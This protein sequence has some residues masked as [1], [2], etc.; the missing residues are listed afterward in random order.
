ML[1]LHIKETTFFDDRDQRFIDIGETTI[2][3]E[4]SLV[5]ISKWEAKWKKSFISSKEKSVEELLDYIRMMTI[6]QNVKPE[7]YL[8]ITEEQFNEVCQYIEDPMTA[9]TF[10]D[11]KKST[12][13]SIITS[14]LVY[15][16][17]IECGIPME[18]QKW[19][20]N[21][22]MTLIRVCKIKMK[23]TSKMTKS[24]TAKMYNNLNEQRKAKLHTR[25]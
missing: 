18:C 8:A 5:S 12:S 23:P 14:E 15:Y 10:N 1:R 20:F 22:L 17:M 9:T 2:S 16:W 4:H 25:G 13:S 21:R 6:T 3:L 24:D 19:H 11:N 7:T